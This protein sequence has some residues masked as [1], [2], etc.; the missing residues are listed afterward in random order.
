MRVLVLSWDASAAGGGLDPQ[1]AGLA[2]ALADH[3][4]D[5]RVVTRLGEDRHAPDV[6]GIEVHAVTD[7]PPILPAD[8]DGPLLAAQAF[9]ARAT[10]V[11]VRRLQEREVDIV[12]A[13]G[14]Q[15]QPVVAA[16]RATHGAPVAVVLTRTE[17][18]PSRSAGVHATARQ[19]A[20]DAAVLLGPTATDQ[21]A[22][23]G[24]TGAAAGVLPPGTGLPARSPGPPPAGGPLHVAAGPDHDHR[25]LARELRGAAAHRRR[26]TR[27][28]R[29]RPFAVAVLDPDDVTTGVRA[30]ALGVP[31]LAVD[32]PVGE[33]AA[34]TGGGL[35]VEPSGTALAAAADRLAD[36]PDLAAVLGATGAAAAVRHAWPTIAT[37]WRRAVGPAV[38]AGGVAS[39]AATHLHAAGR[40]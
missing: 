2:A 33:L 24:A 23:H 11:A 9:A 32:G 29:R 3:G 18:D 30:L 8:L 12:H 19:L 5:V 6:P 28:W 40:V 38:A 20:A 4:D 25:A 35:V 15:T 22:L 39:S 1:A 37:A 27:S 36:E 17:V 10:S 16:L 21:R 34:G 13:V 7:A 14:W 31:L 26:I